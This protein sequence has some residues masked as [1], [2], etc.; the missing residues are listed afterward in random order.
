[1][2]VAVNNSCHASASGDSNLLWGQLFWNA[3][4]LLRRVLKSTRGNCN[5]PQGEIISFK[6]CNSQWANGITSTATSSTAAVNKQSG[7]K[8]RKTLKYDNK[9]A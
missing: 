8:E 6:F 3:N 9:T 5:S 7:D 4:Q 1:M 2:A